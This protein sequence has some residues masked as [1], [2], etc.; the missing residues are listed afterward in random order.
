MG[1]CL[2]EWEKLR[3]DLNNLVVYDLDIG[4]ERISKLENEIRMVIIEVFFLKGDWIK[5]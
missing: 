1:E 4:F 5:S 2:R 3:K